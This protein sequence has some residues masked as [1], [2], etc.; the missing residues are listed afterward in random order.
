MCAW[1]N[2]YSADRARLVTLAI[3]PPQPGEAVGPAV[4]CGRARVA[5]IFSFTLAVVSVSR[6]PPKIVINFLAES[7]PIPMRYA[8][9]IY[10]PPVALLVYAWFLPDHWRS[11]QSQETF[12][13]HILDVA[14]WWIFA[15]LAWLLYQGIRRLARQRT[16]DVRGFE[17]IKTHRDD[18]PAAK[19]PADAV[20][21]PASR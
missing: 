21:G 8:Q 2:Y 20:N 1:N 13:E 4:C 18:T 14:I 10:L 9:L 3:A 17:I 15:V 11:G 6:W 12:R 19:S 5:N 16:A 7:A